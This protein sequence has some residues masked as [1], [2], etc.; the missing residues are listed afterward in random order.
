MI[1]FAGFSQSTKDTICV[2]RAKF[3]R[4]LT[5]AEQAKGFER[6]RD[7]L[8]GQV[9]TLIARISIKEM[10]ISVRDGQ[11]SDLKNIISSKDA[12]IQT[13]SEQRKIFESNNAA[14]IKQIKKAQR[15]KRFV[16][17]IGLLTTGIAAYFAIK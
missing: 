11:I 4:M 6:Q 12:I 2:D 1:A 3:V 15:G 10:L 13:Q 14:L 8:L 9:D 16:A 5:K 17:F 7:L